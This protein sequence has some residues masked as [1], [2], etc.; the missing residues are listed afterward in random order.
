M[1]E[2]K[3]MK[4]MKAFKIGSITLIVL[5]ALYVAYGLSCYNKS[6]TALYYMGRKNILNQEMQ[7]GNLFYISQPPV[8]WHSIQ[9]YQKVKPFYKQY[10]KE[11]KTYYEKLN[12][13]NE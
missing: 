5:T 11:N 6:D 12:V 2:E 10:R 13:E 4:R 1:S 8:L 9:M 3:Y 7:F